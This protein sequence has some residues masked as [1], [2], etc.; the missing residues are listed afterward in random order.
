MHDRREQ[1]PVDDLWCLYYTL[2]ELIEGYLPWRE[3]ESV[4]EMA[5]AKKI[6]KH[7]HIF[8]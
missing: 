8:P 3:M 1:G 2:A 4:D 7:D 6:L 5:Q